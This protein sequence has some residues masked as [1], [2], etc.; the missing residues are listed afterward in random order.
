VRRAAI[1]AHDVDSFVLVLGAAGYK[2]QVRRGPSGDALGYAVARSGDRKA[3]GEWVFYSGSRLAPDLSLPALQRRWRDGPARVGRGSPWVAARRSVRRAH[4]NFHGDGRGGPAEDPAG[5]AG[6]VGDVLV[7]VAGR[8]GVPDGWVEAAELAERA[9][10][11]AGRGRVALG[12]LA[13]DLRRAARGLLACHA[14]LPAHGEYDLA[15]YRLGL[16]LHL[17]RNRQ[18]PASRHC[19]RCFEGVHARFR[20]GQRHDRRSH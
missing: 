16:A 2:V 4:Q 12:P 15:G 6:G 19:E 7:A 14:W 9:G 10:R 17:R 5:V 13:A 20:A 1:A 11:V 8:V 18:Q 3:A